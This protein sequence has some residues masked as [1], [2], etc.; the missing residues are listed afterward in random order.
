MG[1]VISFAAANANSSSGWREWLSWGYL[2][3]G[4]LCGLACVYLNN[5]LGNGNWNIA[6]GASFKYFSQLAQPFKLQFVNVIFYHY[7]L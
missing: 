6:A 3:D 1:I 7:N 4:G 5:S 2:T